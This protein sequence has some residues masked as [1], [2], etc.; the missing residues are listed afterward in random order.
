MG[1]QERR[2]REKSEMQGKILSTAADILKSEG[3]GA[4]SIRK[5]ANKIEY[6]PAIV[7][8]YFKDKEDIIDH[9]V[10]LKYRQFLLVLSSSDLAGH[11]SRETLEQNL[12]R[13]IRYATEMG[14]EYK[15]VMFS[16]SP[17]IL[18]RTSVLHPGAAAE[19]P[20][21]TMLRDTLKKI[22]ADCS[23]D[24]S[25]L[26]VLAQIIWASTFGLIIRLIIEKVDQNQKDRLIDAYIDFVLNALHGTK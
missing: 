5:I 13:F 17:A 11:T 19:K 2:E 24:E 4:I 25:H 8:H 15:I 14:E 26:E 21:V 9:L 7:Y 3:I 6:S 16:E 12:R 10:A 22:L 20:A 18:A 1:I 23:C